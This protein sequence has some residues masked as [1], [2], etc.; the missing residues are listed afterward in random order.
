MLSNSDETLGPHALVLVNQAL[1]HWSLA[2]ALGV[3]MFCTL[4]P[5][6]PGSP[7]GPSWVL[8]QACFPLA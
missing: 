5:L 7:P 6:V 8:S 3:D 1:C 4:G 2:L